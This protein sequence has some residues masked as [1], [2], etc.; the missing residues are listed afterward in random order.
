MLF[1]E[2]D[3]IAEYYSNI[4]RTFMIDQKKLA[5]YISLFSHWNSLGSS[6]AYYIHTYFG[7]NHTLENMIKIFENNEMYEQCAIVRDWIVEINQIEQ[8]K[9]NNKIT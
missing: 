7:V 1:E 5:S 6:A 8:I 4:D 9:V 2:E 3:E